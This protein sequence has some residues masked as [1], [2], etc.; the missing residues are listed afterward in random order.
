MQVDCCRGLLGQHQGGREGSWTGQR[1]EL[2][3]YEAATAASAHPTKI[4]RVCAA[5]PSYS[6]L[7]RGAGPLHFPHWAVI[8]CGLP[9]G[10]GPS[11]EG[12]RSLQASAILGG[13]T[14]RRAITRQHSQPP[15][16]RCPKLKGRF[17]RS[18]RKKSAHVGGS[19]VRGVRATLL[20][21]RPWASDSIY[22][23]AS[24]QRHLSTPTSGKEVGATAD[25]QR[26]RSRLAPFV[27]KW[28]EK[29]RH[30]PLLNTYYVLVP[31]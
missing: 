1:E 24:D 6:E 13:G 28:W 23:D 10:K 5:L 19:V 12:G 27:L 22:P 29:E 4:G 11:L 17:G 21:V 8:G 14:Q 2:S 25:G 15:E 16:K 30:Y 26:Q 9:L 18:T 31:C 3:C 20:S 7:R